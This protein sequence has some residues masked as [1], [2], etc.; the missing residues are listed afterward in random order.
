M[1]CETNETYAWSR[2]LQVDDKIT[3]VSFGSGMDDLYYFD[4]SEIIHDKDQFEMPVPREKMLRKFEV[5]PSALAGPSFYFFSKD[6]EIEMQEESSG[7]SKTWQVPKVATE[8]LRGACLLDEG[9][10]ALAGKAC[11]TFGIEI[12]GHPSSA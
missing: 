8:T 2:P 10:A 11:A 5:L 4:G 6:G 12:G 7:K 9:N 3:S 1:N